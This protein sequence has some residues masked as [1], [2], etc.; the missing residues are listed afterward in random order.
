MHNAKILQGA[1]KE[2]YTY[3]YEIL[4]A[5]DPMNVRQGCIGFSNV[6][7]SKCKFTHIHY[8]NTYCL[9]KG[10]DMMWKFTCYTVWCD[11]YAQNNDIIADGVYHKN[12][13]N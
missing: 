9:L 8:R 5:I 6:Q 7:P 11:Q 3:K 13:I 1:L 10:Y 12:V 2:R 4:D